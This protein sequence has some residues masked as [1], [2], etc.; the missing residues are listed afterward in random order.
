MA[1]PNQDDLL[2]DIDPNI[3][4]EIL[5]N[6]NFSNIQNKKKNDKENIEK[7]KSCDKNKICDK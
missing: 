7:N 6:K 3:L 2:Q 5:D 1:Q 4:N